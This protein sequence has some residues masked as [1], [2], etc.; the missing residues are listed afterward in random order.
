M[1]NNDNT[2]FDIVLKLR[3]LGFSVIPSGKGE[4]GKSPLVPWKRYQ[5]TP[6]AP[7]TLRYWKSNLHPKLWG[8]VTNSEVAVIDADTPE[9]REWLTAEMGEP[10]V[11]TPRGGAH[12]YINSKGNPMKT[13]AGLLLGVDV[14]GVGGFVNI[15]GANATGEYKINTVPT[16]DTLI[17]YSKIPAKILEAFNTTEVPDVELDPDGLIPEGKRNDWLFRR[18]CKYRADGDGEEVI[19]QKIKIDYEKRC[20][21]DSPMDDKELKACCQSASKYKPEKKRLS[22]ASQLVELV[23]DMDLFHTAD[24]QQYGVISRNGHSETWS[25]SSQAISQY[26][27]QRYYEKKGTAAPA[28]AIKDALNV[29]RGKAQ[30]DG[31][32]KQVFVR[33]AGYK[34]NIYLDL[35]NSDYQV[36]EISAAGWKVIQCPPICFIR[37]RGMAPLP[38]P[39]RGGHINDLRPF[40]NVS[41]EEWPLLLAWLI[42]TLMPDGPYPILVLTGEQGSAK[43]TVAKTL[44]SL[45]D[46][47]S[48]P[49]RSLP[50]E[51]R[52]LA[53]SANNA[54]I[55]A[56]DN[57]SYI[58]GWLSDALCRLST[59]GGFAT[60]ELRTDAE[61]MLFDSKR[62]SIINGIGDI[63]TRSDLLNRSIFLSLPT[64]PDDS[65]RT[66]AEISREFE[67]IRP[68]ILASILDAI[69]TALDNIDYVTIEGMPRMADF[70]KWV[71]AAAPVLDI[72]P[73]DF[74]TS[75]VRNMSENDQLA[76]ESAPAIKE[77][78]AF[79]DNNDGEWEGTVSD[80]LEELD[81]IAGD[82][83]RCRKDWPKNPKSLGAIINR[84]SPNLRSIGIGVER[85]RMGGTGGRIIHITGKP[86]KCAVQVPPRKRCVVTELETG[87]YRIQMYV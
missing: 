76:L 17:K 22:I 23:K 16:P 77:L 28:Q 15:V 1:K 10:H 30:F 81:W 20:S 54:W 40:I 75:Y 18:A 14:R 62:P 66:E 65:R 38:I 87:G 83:S 7:N 11:I 32:E 2:M 86:S 12:W 79:L 50:R 24:S 67:L 52:D 71:V 59:G 34:N 33:I 19:F 47:S 3:E 49:L 9:A 26:L 45:I 46:P 13:A 78:I 53:I 56:F 37:R 27:S 35:C 8:V 36:V 6:P 63:A 69:S 51:E 72:D 84:L 4:K 85:Y 82:S 48:I 44:R 31:Q 60:R 80:L 42:S 74:L 41:D 73:N 39:Q 64:I 5:E 61:E 70:V 25:L 43:S 68:K 58:T 21:K 29:L 55:L 57:I